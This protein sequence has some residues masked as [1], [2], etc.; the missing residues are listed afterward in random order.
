MAVQPDT[1]APLPPGRAASGAAKLVL[2]RLKGAQ[3][4]LNL[5]V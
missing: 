1:S 5:G 3:V 2:P 4:G